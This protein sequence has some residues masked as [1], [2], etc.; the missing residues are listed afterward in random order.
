MTYSFLLLQGLVLSDH[1]G[2][3]QVI[4][5]QDNL[6]KQIIFRQFSFPPSLEQDQKRLLVVDR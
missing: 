1:G 4:T 5:G 2:G 6:K 3:G